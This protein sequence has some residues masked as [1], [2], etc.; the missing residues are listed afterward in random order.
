MKEV[1][2]NVT[3]TEKIRETRKAKEGDP[4]IFTWA[5]RIQS[6]KNQE[7]SPQSETHHPGSLRSAGAK[8]PGRAK[9]P[10]DVVPS[11]ALSAKPQS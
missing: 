2:L 9:D 1:F 10:G 11:S 7:R 5:F 8:A 4:A 3:G 6:K